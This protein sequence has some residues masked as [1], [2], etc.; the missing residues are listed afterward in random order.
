MAKHK[1]KNKQVTSTILFLILLVAAGVI[2]F[3][4]CKIFLKDIEK[5]DDKKGNTT[6]VEKPTRKPV[7][8]DEEK[9]DVEAPQD[10]GP[11][12]KAI[13]YEGEDPNLRSELT[14]VITYSSIED[15]ILSLRVNIDQYVSSGECKLELVQEGNVLYS[16]IVSLMDA[17]STSTCDGF[18]AEI[19]DGMSGDIDIVITIS[20]D[21]KVGVINGG[22]AL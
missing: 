13:Q 14:G 5:G 6:I 4:A 8:R 1:T 19:A 15:G 18:D 9:L 2:A 20:G 7:P 12:E 3:F 10:E 22:L 16:S 21:G 17:A 11:E